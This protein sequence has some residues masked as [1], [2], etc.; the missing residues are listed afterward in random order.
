MITHASDW[1]PDP[2]F[3]PQE[4]V[5]ISFSRFDPIIL[6]SVSGQRSLDSER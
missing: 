6:M 1:A 3:S 4:I 5:H 2:S